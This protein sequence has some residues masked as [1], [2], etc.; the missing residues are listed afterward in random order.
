MTICG[1]Q[2]NVDT[3]LF[4]RV[5]FVPISAQHDKKR[6]RNP[7][8]LIGQRDLSSGGFS[9]KSTLDLRYPCAPHGNHTGTQR[10]ISIK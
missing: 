3:N 2:V 4:A 10:L 1:I 6:D 5:V 7:R 8:I 9:L